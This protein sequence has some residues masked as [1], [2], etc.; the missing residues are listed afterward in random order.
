[1]AGLP[2][3]REFHKPQ[4]YVVPS[5]G[6]EILVN[7]RAPPDPAELVAYRNR[8]SDNDSGS[9]AGHQDPVGAFPGTAQEYSGSSQYY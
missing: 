2:S 6:E 4:Q 1:M 7:L 3:G 8:G 5:L 9:D